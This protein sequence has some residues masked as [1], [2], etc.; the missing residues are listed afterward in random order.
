MF[1][2]H[3]VTALEND[4]KYNK[5]WQGIERP[6]TAEDVCRLR[7]TVQIEHTLAR[8][9]AEVVKVEHPVHGDSGRASLPPV[10][11]S[12][13]RSVGPTYLR[14]NLCKKSIAIDLKSPRGVELIKRLVPR[15]DVLGEN[16]RGGTLERL[17]LGYRTL[18]EIHPGLIYISVSGFGNL[19]PSPYASWGAYAPIGE[20]MGGLYE[21][22][23]EPGRRR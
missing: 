18:S 11:D 12:D 17:G 3:D 8:M 19:H 22:R 14:N 6:Y 4:W 20:A 21:D 2:E 1:N 7:G 15:F 5:R 16:F 23:R 9:G 10:R 13:G